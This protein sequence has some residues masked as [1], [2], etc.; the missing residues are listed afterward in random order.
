MSDAVLERIRAAHEER[1]AAGS[2]CVAAAQLLDAA[3]GELPPEEAR[4]VLSHAVGC[5]ACGAC[6]RVARELLREL[7]E[8]P[9]QE[10]A[11]RRWHLPALGAALAAAAAIALIPWSRRSPPLPP[12]T[13]A[14]EEAPLHALSAEA[15][16]RARFVLRWTAAGE[17]ARYSLTVTTR[18][19]SLVHERT[20]LAATEDVVP[21]TALKNLPAGALL[22]WTV[23][24][25]LPGGKR[26]SSPAFLV[27]LE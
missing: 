10:P 26:I 19:L 7:G 25:L 24:A 27:R 6:L 17:G 11:V 18:D 3:R 12:A 20:G 16:P 13:R 14:V 22:G 5:G 4:A 8:A 21:E 23:E 15:L 1:A 9:A 2:G